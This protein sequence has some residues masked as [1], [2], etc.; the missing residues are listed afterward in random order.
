MAGFKEI[1]APRTNRYL[2]LKL[3]NCA[4][5]VKYTA[6]KCVAE[7]DASFC[8]SVQDFWVAAGF[9][10]HTDE[11]SL[12]KPAPLWVVLLCIFLFKWLFNLVWRLNLFASPGLVSRWQLTLSELHTGLHLKALLFVEK[13]LISCAAG[14]PYRKS[15]PQRGSSSVS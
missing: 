10:N 4:D 7:A 14:R 5:K 12:V 6:G 8:I 3:L 2:K 1:K 9:R 13:H 11:S 15:A